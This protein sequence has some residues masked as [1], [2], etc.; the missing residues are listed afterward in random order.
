MAVDVLDPYVV[1]ERKVARRLRN[2][3]A[4]RRVS[5][6]LA[7]VAAA[8]IHPSRDGVCRGA[9]MSGL[10]EDPVASATRVAVETLIDELDDL[11]EE[12]SP[13]TLATLAAE[14]LAADLG[15]E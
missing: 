6:V 2:D 1:L 5:A 13:H 15:I 11:V 3:D 7:E 10:L 9:V 8:A 4:H 14:Q 12:L